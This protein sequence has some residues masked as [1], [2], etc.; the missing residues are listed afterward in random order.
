MKKERFNFCSLLL[1]KTFVGLL[2]Y[3]TQHTTNTQHTH[4]GYPEAPI[5]HTA[6]RAQYLLGGPKKTQVKKTKNTSKI[7]KDLYTP[8]G[9][10]TTKL[11]L[12]ITTTQ[13]HTTHAE[14]RREKDEVIRK[15][16][17]SL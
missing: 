13:Q 11:T 7:N 14:S 6:I 8:N 17:Q 10:A 1:S 9:V 15:A 16:T 12:E 3:K 4:G 2:L 5:T